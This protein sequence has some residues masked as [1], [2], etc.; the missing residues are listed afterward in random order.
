MFSQGFSAG[1]FGVLS[2]K[3]N[4]K[5]IKTKYLTNGNVCRILKFHTLP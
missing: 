2:K 3:L 4:P 1:R 5:H